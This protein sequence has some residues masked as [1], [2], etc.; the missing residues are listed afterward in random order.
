MQSEND[1]QLVLLLAFSAQSNT[2]RHLVLRFWAETSSCTTV[3]E[4][5]LQR[6]MVLSSVTGGDFSQAGFSMQPGDVHTCISIGSS[7]RSLIVAVTVAAVGRV[8][9]SSQR[10]LT[11]SPI[12]QR[13]L[14]DLE[15]QKWSKSG[16]GD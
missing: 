6:S 16:F 11:P 14:K 7:S 2:L 15:E 9:R 8:R 1:T 4:H 10:V 13:F 3:S 12:L 5:I